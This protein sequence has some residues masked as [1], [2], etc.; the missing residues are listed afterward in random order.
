[1]KVSISKSGAKFAKKTKYHNIIG[2]SIIY[3][4]PN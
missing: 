4:V 2:H 3:D 1:M